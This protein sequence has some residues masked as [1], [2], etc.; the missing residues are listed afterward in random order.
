MKE[1]NYIEIG[2]RIRK[3]RE[4][5]L[6]T[7]EKLAEM[8]DVSVKFVSDIELGAKGM[9]LKT[10]NKLSQI[11]LVSTDHILYGSSSENDP[12]ELVR[13]LQK[14]PPEKSQYLED[15]IKLFIRSSQ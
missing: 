10:L 11:L 14:C 3:S 4:S 12:A 9:S 5:Q 15:I 13:L 6:L 7:Q 8:M 1:L 2:A